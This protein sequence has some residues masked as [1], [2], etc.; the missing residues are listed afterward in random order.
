MYYGSYGKIASYM[1][2]DDTE[3]MKAY[4]HI[5]QTCKDDSRFNN[6]T[7]LIRNNIG[8]IFLKQGKYVLAEQQF[9]QSYQLS[10]SDDRIEI[11]KKYPF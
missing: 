1:F 6:V 7:A 8:S 5:L 11:P 10:K 4:N 2:K 9:T 3:S